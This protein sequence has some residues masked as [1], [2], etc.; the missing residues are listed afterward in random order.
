MYVSR[1]DEY[2]ELLARGATRLMCETFELQFTLGGIVAWADQ[3]IFDEFT[4][5]GMKKGDRWKICLGRRIQLDEED[6]DGS[7]FVEDFLEDAVLFP[8]HFPLSNRVAERWETVEVTSGVWETRPMLDVDDQRVQGGADGDAGED[9]VEVGDKYEDEDDSEID[10]D[11]YDPEAFPGLVDTDEAFIRA[12]LQEDLALGPLDDADPQALGITVN[13]DNVVVQAGYESDGSAESALEDR[14]GETMPV[15]IDERDADPGWE[16]SA[17]V[18]DAAWPGSDFEEADWARKS[19]TLSPSD[20]VD[21]KDPVDE[22]MDSSS[23][24]DLDSAEMLS[25][26]EVIVRRR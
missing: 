7:Q 2:E 16:I 4:G 21:G 18:P 20:E 13:P 14:E 17:N 5:S 8:L 12:L 19:K 23:D 24:S 1:E 15:D 26:D 22:D 9:G 10:E 25:G 11:L 6:L 3:N